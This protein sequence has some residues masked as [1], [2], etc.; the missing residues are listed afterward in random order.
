[1]QL[2]LN[3]TFVKELNFKQVEQ[4]DGLENSLNFGLSAG[5]NQEEPS[6]HFTVLFDFHLSDSSG[7]EIELKYEGAFET[8]EVV[9]ED[10]MDS[11]WPQVNGAAI[12]YP[13]LRAFIS[14]LTINSGYEAAVIPSVNFQQMYTEQVEL[15]KKEAEQAKLDNL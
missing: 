5:W 1:M 12:V 4:S 3:K 11:S 13:F 15:A 6:N 9:N 10:F 8:D 7:Y 14:N 2:T